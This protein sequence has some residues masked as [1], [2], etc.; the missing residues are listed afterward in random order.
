[1]NPKM[2]MKYRAYSEDHP[3]IWLIVSSSTLGAIS[4][5]AQSPKTLYV[6]QD[7]GHGL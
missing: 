4:V 7:K 1:M 5:L 2:T 6:E 3:N